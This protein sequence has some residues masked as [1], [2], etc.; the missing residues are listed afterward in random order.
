MPKVDMD[1]AA[2]T[3]ATWHV[4]PGDRVEKGAP[5]FDI[6][7]D[8]AAMEVEAPA[9]GVLHHP[10]PEGTEVPIGAPV[11][12]LY[13]EGEAVGAPQGVE[14]RELVAEHGT[15]IPLAPATG[16]HVPEIVSDAL[17]GG[18]TSETMAVENAA[19][20]TGHLPGPEDVFRRNL[21]ALTASRGVESLAELAALA[22]L[23]NL[24]ALAEPRF[25]PD[26]ARALGVDTAALTDPTLAPRPR[27]TP[28]A[29]ALARAASL[30][31]RTVG[32]SGPRRR[33]QAADVEAATRARA[34]APPPAA[35]SP[36]DGALAVTR[37][38]G[39]TGTPVVLLHGFASDATSWAP[40]EKVLNGAPLVRMELPGHGKSAPLDVDDF[41]GLAGLVRRTFVDL[42]LDRAH[43]VGHSLGGALAL[44]L[45]DTRPRSVESVTLIAP[46]GLGPQINGEVLAGLCRA[47]R[48]ESL[49]PW[50][51]E[52][53]ADDAQITEGYARAAMASRADPAL[54]A[55]QQRL[56]DALF[57][58]GVQAFDLRAALSR[59]DLPAR[60]IWGRRDKIIPWHHALSAQGDVALHLFDDLGHLPHIEAAEKVGNLLRRFL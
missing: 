5:L 16:G 17:V 39:G 26:V 14:P 50:L 7:T 33:I 28:R 44:A 13:A 1:M 40:L 51:R 55:A 54:R 38:L 46:A 22:G 41:A 24:G 31:L 37:S 8:K 48:V 47:Q 3:I 27:A 59:L 49:A 32:G 25:L 35:R 56:A 21:D 15:E 19:A 23:P 45:A 11:A 57:P 4:A 12:W 6:E 53:V 36:R 2:G 42:G 34:Q 18:R 43:V 20:D 10:V 60:I 9:D 52:L 30:D 29:R 58:D